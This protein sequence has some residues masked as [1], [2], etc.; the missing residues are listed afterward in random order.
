[1]DLSIDCR[2]LG[3]SA[4]EIGGRISTF[5]APRQ[6]RA[7]WLAGGRTATVANG[8]E[9]RVEHIFGSNGGLR[10]VAVWACSE[11][12]WWRRAALV[13]TVALNMRS[14]G[15]KG[16]VPRTLAIASL[17]AGDH[18]DMVAK[19][20]SWA[21]RALVPHDPDAVRTFL[22]ENDMVLAARIKR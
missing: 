19:A 16:D 22:A 17:L 8:P 20:L 5:T 11:N 12:L 4:S 13:S 6:Y 21:L 15:G 1:L 7:R 10:C 18:E 2:S 9:Y 3:V 14:Q